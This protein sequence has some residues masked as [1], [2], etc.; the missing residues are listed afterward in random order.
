MCDVRDHMFVLTNSGVEHKEPNLE[1]QLKYNAQNDQI[2]W[3]GY[4]D[5]LF[6]KQKKNTHFMPNFH[7][8]YRIRNKSLLLKNESHCCVKLKSPMVY[9]TYSENLNE[10]FGCAG[11]NY[12]HN[13]TF[14]RASKKRSLL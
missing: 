9:C 1:P 13:V 10:F 5:I 7:K 3:T 12:R 6:G 8:C 4:I 11:Q 14:G 2:E